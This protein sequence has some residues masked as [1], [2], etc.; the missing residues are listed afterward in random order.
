MLPYSAFHLGLHC[1]QSTCLTVSRMKRVKD[2]GAIHLRISVY[3]LRTLMASF[4][5]DSAYHLHN[6]FTPH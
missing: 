3:L 1:L 2:T 5:H 4:A 6:F